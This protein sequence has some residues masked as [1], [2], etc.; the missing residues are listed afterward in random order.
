MDSAGRLK[1]SA[2]DVY[3][4]IPLGYGAFFEQQVEHDG[5]PLPAEER[6]KIARELEKRRS[7][8]P[9]QKRHRFEKELAERSYL[10]E[11]PDAFDFRI[12][13]EA[14]LP[15]GPAWVV[16]ATPRPG[17]AAK[18]RY[19]HFFPKMHGTLWIDKKDLQW[20]KADAVATD[21]VTFGLFLARLAKGSHIILE[22]TRLPDGA[23]VPHAL[24]ARAE[25][26]TFLLF[27]H[28]F[29]ENITYSD[30][31]KAEALTASGAAR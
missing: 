10:E 29:D 9:A 27:D 14:N 18:S 16:E 7:E 13:G 24:S 11:V 8:S 26:R 17:Y 4:I 30:Y 19:A 1:S 3:D 25:A 15:T 20:V 28:N 5:E 6:L 2:V 23:W 31:R 21:T 12:A 22:Q